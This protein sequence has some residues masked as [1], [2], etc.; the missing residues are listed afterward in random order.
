MAKTSLISR[1][2]H[3]SGNTLYSTK[4]QF[5]ETGVSHEVLIKCSGEHPVLVNKKWFGFKALVR[6]EINGYSE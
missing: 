6:R 1:H 4:A 3:C 2:E 5:S